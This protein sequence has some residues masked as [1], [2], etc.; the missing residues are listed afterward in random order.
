MTAKFE[1]KNREITITAMLYSES[2]PGS[3]KYEFYLKADSPVSTAISSTAVITIE[4]YRQDY[5]DE[6]LIYSETQT[7]D[8]TIP[9][10]A[11]ESNRGVYYNSVGSGTSTQYRLEEK[12]HPWNNQTYDYVTY[13]LGA[14]NWR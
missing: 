14:D 4:E 3:I 7:V 8:F 6:E 13:K 9:V 2:S 1:Q 10:G 5:D 12:K 11:T